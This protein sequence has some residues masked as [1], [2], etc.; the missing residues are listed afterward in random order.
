MIKTIAE[1]KSILRKQD[2]EF[3]IYIAPNGKNGLIKHYQRRGRASWKLLKTFSVL[4]VK[5]FIS[6]CLAKDFTEL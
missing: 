3:R 2:Q 1:L 5:R 4:N 6:M